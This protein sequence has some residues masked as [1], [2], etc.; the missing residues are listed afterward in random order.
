MFKKRYRVVVVREISE[1]GCT[2]LDFGCGLLQFFEI[3]YSGRSLILQGFLECFLG[4]RIPQPRLPVPTSPL[5]GWLGPW[6][7]RGTPFLPALGSRLTL[8]LAAF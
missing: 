8:L 6:E 7:A 5:P 2:S 3:A 1:R 4:Q